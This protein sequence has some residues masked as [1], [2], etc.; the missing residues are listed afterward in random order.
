MD[1]RTRL[2]PLGMVAASGAMGA[3]VFGVLRAPD[4]GWQSTEVVFALVLGV[5]L[6]VGFVAWERVAPAPDGAAVTVRARGCSLPPH[7]PSS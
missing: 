6:L 4:A 2:D 3:L 1:P 7:S 5:I